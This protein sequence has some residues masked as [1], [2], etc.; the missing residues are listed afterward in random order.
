MEK[1]VINLGDFEIN[2]RLTQLK[3]I[4]AFLKYF[5]RNLN[6][7]QEDPHNDEMISFSLT[8]EETELMKLSYNEVLKEVEYEKPFEISE[9]LDDLDVVY[10]EALL[11]KLIQ[12]ERINSV[13][14]KTAIFDGTF[15]RI[16]KRISKEIENLEDKKYHYVYALVDPT[17][18]YLPFYIGKGLNKRVFSHFSD[19]EEKETISEDFS[20]I[21][22]IRDLRGL[23]YEKNDVSR[24]LAKN[25]TEDEAFLLESF[26]I[27]TVFG[28]DNLTNKVHG[29]YQNRFRLYDTLE[30]YSDFDE[31]LV[32]RKRVNQS[33]E[34]LRVKFLTQG[35]DQPLKMISI[36]L[37]ELDFSE[38]KVLDSGEFGMEA[39]IKDIA[40]LKIFLRN[41][42]IYL[43]LWPRRKNQKIAFLRH[44]ETLGIREHLKRND[45][46][47][48][49]AQW[50]KKENR[51]SDVYEVVR[52]AKRLI[53]FLNITSREDLLKFEEIFVD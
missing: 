50:S 1:S 4:V 12:T 33:R 48:R 3:S 15:Y 47:F 6:I 16:L 37:P 43:E 23:G 29:K 5:E 31:F 26:L 42:F 35:K 40:N 20:K 21:S 18:D 2:E 25:L 36:M 44:F 53:E 39:N 38:M 13:Y 49:P 17:N 45:L 52:R 14:W 46:V 32:G 28:F 41:K 30:N 22:K 7:E 19:D 24:V 10:A 27:K 34:N 51:T 8:V 9:Y 11:V